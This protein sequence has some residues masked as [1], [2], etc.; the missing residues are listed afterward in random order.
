MEYLDHVISEKGEAVDPEKI[1]SIVSWLVL[2]N[3][4]VYGVFWV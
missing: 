4:K 1:R 3:V 2:H